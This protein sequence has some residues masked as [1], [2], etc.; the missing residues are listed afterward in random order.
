M[1]ASVIQL[2]LVSH[3]NSGKTTL[4]RTLL[5]A[6]VGEVRDA[7]HVTQ[8]AQSHVL[9]ETSEGDRLALWDTPGFGD[10][11]RLARRLAMANNPIGWFLREVIDRYRDRVFWL[12][13]KALRA[14][15]ERA[16]VV[17]YL[18]N[19]SEAPEDAGY[20]AA[21]MQ[22]LDWLGK[23]VILLLNQLGPPRPA[24][25][26]MAEQARWRT[27]LA[28]YRHVRATLAL[29]A[30]ARCWVHEQA[31]F[32]TLAEVLPQPL[33]PAHTRL[34]AQWRHENAARFEASMHALARQIGAAAHELQAVDVAEGSVLKSAL[35]IVGVGRD[36]AKRAQE[37]AMAALVGRTQRAADAVTRA[38]LVLHRLEPR[39]AVLINARLR[40]TFT[41]RAPVDKTLAGLLGAILTGA[42]TG[43]TTDLLAGGLTF[44][45]GALLGGL[46]GGM[47]AAGAVWGFNAGTDRNHPEL[48]YSDEFLDSLLVTG[49]LRYLAV[50]HFGRGRGQFVE[51]E[52]P[53]F[54]QGAVERA[55]SSGP[56]GAAW[57]QKV[58]ESE[59][60]A[61]ELL[62]TERLSSVCLAVLAELYPGQ[63]LD[64]IRGSEVPPSGALAQK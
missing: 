18:V 20:V 16:D 11:S 2:A 27:H 44:G 32:T 50:A 1:T 25:E 24:A 28:S 64:W 60:A 41:V 13:Q 22:I 21:E 43:L 3:T 42:A 62:L 10:S 54:W 29:D 55:L 5:G 37:Q 51:G 6:D 9:L 36:E 12:S 26:E 33:Q 34:L 46:L 17:L 49:V 14:A 58:R 57:W 4:T 48:R 7:A 56:G 15:R 53:A 59:S 19:S 63:Q 8:D 40:D 30:F 61:G 31:F 35:K 23:P 38:L 39:D 52:S 47:T 45:G